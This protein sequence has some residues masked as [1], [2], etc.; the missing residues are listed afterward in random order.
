MTPFAHPFSGS[1]RSA[2]VAV[3]DW[4]LSWSRATLST[5]TPTSGTAAGTQRREA[6]SGAALAARVTDIDLAKPIDTDTGNRIRAAAIG[7]LGNAELD[8]HADLVFLYT[9]GSDSIL[10]CL[11]SPYAYR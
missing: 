9:P 6:P 8:F 10:Y 3:P 4:W 11:R 2:A 7:A 5:T 1:K